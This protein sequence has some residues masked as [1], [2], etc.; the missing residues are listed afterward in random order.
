MCLLMHLTVAV[1]LL[2]SALPIPR[3]TCDCVYKGQIFAHG[4]LGLMLTVWPSCLLAW[5]VEGDFH[6]LHSFMQSYVGVFHLAIAASIFYHGPGKQGRS[7]IFAR[8]LSAFFCLFTRLFAAYH[9]SEKSTRGLLISA[10]EETSDER[11][12]AL[13]AETTR[14]AEGK[15]S[16][17]LMNALYADAAM[18][19]CY[20]LFHFAFPQNILKLVIKPSLDL[21]SHH[22]MWCRVFGALWLT[23]AVGSLIAVHAPPAFQLTHLLQRLVVQV[24]IFVLH[25][26]GHWIINVFSPNHITAFMIAGFFMSFHISTFY[27]YKKAFA[28]EPKSNISARV[29]IKKMR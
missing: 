18:A 26:Y 23:P 29:E 6:E 9:L 10:E 15:T 14:Y 24:G 7:F 19:F 11:L 8:L 22:Y 17:Y 16:P 2:V 12:T 21:D 4:L 27:R 28:A 13:C 1:P 5:T 20:A 25:V 3:L